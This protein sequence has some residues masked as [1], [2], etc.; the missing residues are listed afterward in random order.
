MLKIAA[1]LLMTSP[2]TPLIFQGEEWNAS[3]PFQY[4]TDHKD[5]ALAQAVREGRRKEFA[6]FVDGA[7]EVP[8][9]QA[10]RRSNDQS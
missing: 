9:P 8:D 2:F 7:D 4:F 5:P 10:P 6:H 3:S 1:A